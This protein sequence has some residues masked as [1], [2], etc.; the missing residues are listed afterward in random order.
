MTGT[1]VTGGDRIDILL[2]A[3]C[4]RAEPQRRNLLN[5]DLM[6]EE[7]EFLRKDWT[8]L[9]HESWGNDAGRSILVA[10]D[11]RL[12]GPRSITRLMHTTKTGHALEK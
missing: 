3:R 11:A 5:S 2:K 8:E 1:G 9:G 12:E 10:Y 6:L 7:S 4:A